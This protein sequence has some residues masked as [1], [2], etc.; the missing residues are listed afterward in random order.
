[1][2]TP[3]TTRSLADDLQQLYDETRAKVGQEDI[4]HI[5]KIAAYSNAIKARSRE[6]L[7]KGGKPDAFKR[8]VT[9]AVLH[10][11]LEFAEL[12]HNIMHGTYDNLPNAKRF[13]S[14]QWVWDFITDPDEWKI[15]HHQNHH[16]FTN[17][18]DKDHDIGYSMIRMFAGQNWYGHHALQPLALGALALPNYFFS[19]YTASS[20]ARVEERPAL[21][22]KTF[23]RAFKLLGKHA[24]RNYI[25]EPL[26]AGSRFLHTVVGNYLGIVL[27]YD[28]IIL[29][30]MLEHHA[31]NVQV[32]VDP[33]PGESRD[34]YF[35]RQLLATSNFIPTSAIDS[36]L[37]SILDEE[38]D[39]PNPPDFEVFYGGLSTH[40][41]H[42]LFPDLPCNRQREIVPQVQAICAAHGLPYNIVPFEEAIP[43]VI[44]RLIKWAVPAGEQEQ[45][46][47][48]TSLVR[49]P[50][51]LFK[52]VNHGM[53]YKVPS[54]YTYIQTTRYFNAPAEVLATR[55]EAGGQALSIHLAKP[56]GWDEQVWDAGAYI[57]L[58]IKIGKEEFVRQYSLTSDSLDSDTLDITV[59]RVEGGRVSNFINDTVKA[60]QFIT[61]VGTPQNDGSFVV[62]QLP[63]LP[64]FIAGGV[65]IT[66]IISMMR[67]LRRDNTDA[68]GTLLYF[69]RNPESIIFEDEIRALAKQARLNVHLICDSAPEH[70]TDLIQE[71]LSPKLLK[72]YI[73]DIC[74][75]DVYVC[76]PPGFIDIVNTQLI[77]LGLPEGRFH[78]ESFTPPTL[79]REPSDGRQYRIHFKR[80]GQEVTIESNV[81]LL[82]AAR[83][84]GI[85]IPSGCE[86]GLCKACVCT[87]VS[88]QTQDEIGKSTQTR[89]TICNSMPRSDIELDV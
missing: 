54:P 59:K 23:E 82:E 29:M 88:G 8:G 50:R 76:A 40:L 49:R 20:A 5:E 42:H 41:E 86:R 21:G 60:G 63:K 15:M 25:Q 39:F 57:S 35:R 4:D 72:Q 77:T 84:V 53:R 79:V 89:I 47:T 28:L 75:A 51:Q 44:K 3:A 12:G 52:R 9:L 17:I 22:L 65:G 61:L 36:Y 69:N 24:R 81:T 10:T 37:K 32:F 64:I 18:I 58:R 7:Q 74:T 26:A 33:G 19:M 43:N 6:L 38:V 73:P 31:H 87:K 66:P 71:K 1:M 13:H 11:L 46:K 62:Q 56:L 83:Q 34:E 2:Q 67:K 14:D 45:Q 48:L 70:R 30:L 80:S 78:T 27:G 16:P 85:Q 55:I 68:Q